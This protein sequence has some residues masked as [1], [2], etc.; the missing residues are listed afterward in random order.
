V[1]D[2]LIKPIEEL[3]ALPEV[4]PAL[5]TRLNARGIRLLQPAD[6]VALFATMVVINL[7]RFG[8]R[9][10]TYPLS[11]YWVGFSVATGICLGVLYFGG[12]YERE[13]GLGSRPRL[14][15]IVALT[16]IAVLVCGGLALVTG[17]YLMP[18][19]NLAVLFVIGSLAL[20]TN[21]RVARWLHVRRQG[22]PRVL[23]VGAPDEVNLARK[24]LEEAHGP[25]EIAGESIGT[26]DLDRD[27]EATGATDVLV[28]SGRLMADL[29]PE[30]LTTLERRG[31]GV[32]QVV[33]ARDSLLGLKD[34]RE[35][36]GMPVVALFSHVLPPSQLRLKRLLDVVL[37]VVFAP[38]LVLLTGG[39][40]LYTRVVAGPPVL[41]RQTRVGQDGRPFTLLKF[42]TMVPDAEA[43]TGAV[44]AE[45]RDP[46][47]VP[48]MAW[49]RAMR[50][51]E[52]P[53][54]WNVLRG[55]MSIVGP[56]PERPELAGRFA[57][58]IPGYTRRT[59]VPPG[60]T[61]LAQVHGRYHTDPEYK[62]GHDIQYLVNWSAVLD[63]QILARTIWVVLS[64]RM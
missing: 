61:G 32:L 7:V 3:G 42:R 13:I 31:I 57:T 17:R 49:V 35:I 39:V 8:L 41:F 54:L 22:L 37:C 50:F 26:M 55:E 9:W 15:R 63:L 6:A 23:L 59:E 11:H 62:L 12:L 64:R 33:S 25:C 10:P 45:S 1:R 28:L 48:G 56:R 27:A 29:Y 19:I 2:E 4:R 18:R 46:R 16:A 24:H 47:I 52:L 43:M 58:L 34:V 44:L 51:D 14:P 5:L 60:I 53:Q 36:G 21:R 30:P 38:V 40:A 20:A